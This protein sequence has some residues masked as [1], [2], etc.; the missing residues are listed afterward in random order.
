ML[1]I[2]GWKRESSTDMVGKLR[3]RMVN[4]ATVAE[5]EVDITAATSAPLLLLLGLGGVS[6]LEV[7]GTADTTLVCP[8]TRTI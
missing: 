4:V 7:V 2:V 8:V 3:V 6:V 5:E 1:V